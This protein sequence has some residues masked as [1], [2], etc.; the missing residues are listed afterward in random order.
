MV[1]I[2]AAALTILLFC[3]LSCLGQERVQEDA[4]PAVNF[5]RWGSVTV[6]NG[7][8][9]DTVRAITQTPDGILWFGTDNGL[10]RFDGRTCQKIE[11]GSPES[12]H[13]QALAAASQG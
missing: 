3:I 12:N 1:S 7:L 4:T 9:S 8:P 11:L 6:F 5:H 2:K 10:A 13:V